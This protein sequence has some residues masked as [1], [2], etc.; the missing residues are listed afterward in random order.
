[1]GSHEPATY[2]R[3]EPG[4]SDFAV[5]STTAL[6]TGKGHHVAATYKA[7]DQIELFI[8]GVREGF[9]PIRVERGDEVR[10]YDRALSETVVKSVFAAEAV[11]N[12]KP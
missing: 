8:N 1:M 12:Q 10:V 11:V 6:Q 5:S 7:N 3:R 2:V 9:E 4:Q